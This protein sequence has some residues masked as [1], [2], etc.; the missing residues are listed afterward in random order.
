LWVAA[1][2]RTE[3]VAR[4]WESE[5]RT[6]TFFGWDGG[7]KGCLAFG[8]APRRNASSLVADLKQRGITPQLVSGDSRA[9][10]EA[11]A[12]QLGRFSI[13]PEKQ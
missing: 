7:L 6:V 8:D 5:G 4:R 12:R 11:V 9:T 3:L 13:L 10:T 2:W 1:G